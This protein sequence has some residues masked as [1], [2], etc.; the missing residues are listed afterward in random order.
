MIFSILFTIKRHDGNG[1]H[2]RTGL[3]QTTNHGFRQQQTVCGKTRLGSQKAERPYPADDP[4]IQ[5]WFAVEI[6]PEYLPFEQMPVCPEDLL[7]IVIRHIKIPNPVDTNRAAHIAAAG[8]FEIAD[9]G[10]ISIRLHVSR[11]PPACAVHDPCPDLSR[12]D[13]VPCSPMLPFCR[14]DR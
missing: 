10:R 9:D 6:Q 5:E 12:R 4:G 7:K 14:A 13:H 2:R 8:G 11:S 3:R 1:N